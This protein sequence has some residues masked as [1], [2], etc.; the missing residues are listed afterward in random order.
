M[1]TIKTAIVKML[2]MTIVIESNLVSLA[3]GQGPAD[4]CDGP[5]QQRAP[6]GA[7]K[8]TIQQVPERVQSNRCQKRYNPTGARKGTL[9]QVPEKVNSGLI[10]HCT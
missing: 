8:G 2:N 4:R 6:T 3:G 1:S 9:Q 7:R 5:D 10:L